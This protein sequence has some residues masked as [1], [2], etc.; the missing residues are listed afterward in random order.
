MQ[1]L[2][3][4]QSLEV[5]LLLDSAVIH[6]FLPNLDRLNKVLFLLGG[7][8]LPLDHT[9]IDTTRK[10]ICTAVHKNYELL[11]GKLRETGGTL[12]NLFLYLVC[13]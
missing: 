2:R 5:K 6:S 12:V 1:I 4:G 7:Q 8:S 11:I 9:V 13:K 10:F 3:S